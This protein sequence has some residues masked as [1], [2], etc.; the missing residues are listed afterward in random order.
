MI[1]S[2][3]ESAIIGCA[4]F[5]AVSCNTVVDYDVPAH[6]PGLVVTSFFSPD[7]TWSVSLHRTQPIQS[8]RN[9]APA[10]VDDGVVTIVRNDLQMPEEVLQ[11]ETDGYY[12]SALGTRP[13]PG[14]RYTVKATSPGLTELAEGTS[15][16][17]QRPE[18]ADFSVTELEEP[19]DRDGY[20]KD[21]HHLKLRI[22]GVPGVSVY[23][24]A[25]FEFRES[26][27][28]SGFRHLFFGCNDTAVYHGYGDIDSE[29]VDQSTTYGGVAIL[30]AKHFQNGS[31]ELT[32]MFN[33]YKDTRRFMIVVS[34][35]ST[36]YFEYQRTLLANPQ[37]DSWLSDDFLLPT[38]IYTNIEGGYGVF[39][40]YA[41]TKEE[42][43]LED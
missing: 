29:D 15:V 37:G 1:R 32:L 12:R 10:P 8:A 9:T 42:F 7:S 30:S 19:V 34:A 43:E 4:V 5:C 16:T 14:G 25:F 13:A 31:R 33:K 6:E 26:G 27:S 28:Q 24:V 18:I 36:D 39:A 11:L 23:R 2:A 20:R 38:P 41:D 17:P 22:V 35:L 21:T 40:G 3:I